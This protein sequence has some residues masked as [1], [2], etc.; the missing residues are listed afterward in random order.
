MTNKEPETKRLAIDHYAKVFKCIT[1]NKR[2]L[3][4]LSFSTRLK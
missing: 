2:W 4:L 1:E 3:T